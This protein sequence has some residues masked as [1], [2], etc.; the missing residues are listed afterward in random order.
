VT[1]IGQN[2]SALFYCFKKVISA[3]RPRD[4]KRFLMKKKTITNKKRDIA[5]FPVNQ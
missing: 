1:Y 5:L 2:R 3:E 4:G